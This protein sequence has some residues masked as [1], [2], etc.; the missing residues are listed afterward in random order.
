VDKY[1][2][3]NKYIMCPFF[4]EQQMQT[5]TPK[6]RRLA[7]TI[8]LTETQHKYYIKKYRLQDKA[9]ERIILINYELHLIRIHDKPCLFIS[10]V[11]KPKSFLRLKDK[12]VQELKNMT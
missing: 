4:Q 10:G 8:E 5:I 2:L 7:W 12:Y 11:L 3:K 9:D 6:T 1:T